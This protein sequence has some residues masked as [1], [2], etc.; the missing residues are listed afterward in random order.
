MS[1]EVPMDSK[2]YILQ[3][4]LPNVKAGARYEH[5]DRARSGSFYALMKDD[6]K[7]IYNCPIGEANYY[8]AASYAWDY[9]TV[10]NS[11]EWFKLYEPTKTEKFK[12]EITRLRDFLNEF[13]EEQNG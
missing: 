5:Y 13:I 3:K 12:K 7:Y 10:E 9:D 2:I 4:D 1:R 6:T 11:P 8:G